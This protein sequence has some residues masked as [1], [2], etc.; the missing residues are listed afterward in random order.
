MKIKLEEGFLDCF[1][2]LEDP[3]SKR[4]RLYSMSEILLVTL[5][6]SICGAEG[7]QDV[8]DFGNIKIE[9][10]REYLPYKNGIPS[11]DTFRRFF[12]AINPD[13]FQELFREWVKI[14]A[15][16][17]N[18]NV[19]AIDGKSS[20]RSYDDDKKMLHTLSAYA[21]ES[22]LVLGQE[23]VSDKSNEIT[24]IP[25]LLDWL[26]IKGSIVTI[27]AM[28]CQHKIANKILEQQS[29]YIFC[30]KGNQGTLHEDIKLYFSDQELLKKNAKYYNDYDKAHG[31]IEHRKCSVVSDVD[32]LKKGHAEWKSIKSIILI[33][34]T[35]EIKGKVSTE[36]RYYISSLTQTPEKTLSSIRSHWAI[37][38][39]LHWVLDMSFGDDQCRIRKENA[40]QV[41]AVIRH[42]A[43]NL[44]QLAKAQMK[45]QSIKRLRKMAGWDNNMLSYILQQKF[46]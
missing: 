27:D 31:R 3:R 26:D 35:R 1:K 23:K 22:R 7:W 28:G 17:L 39:A 45:R 34:S 12:R 21:T 44:L 33:E 13:K 40:P 30:L 2:K 11:D 46:S 10:L 8:E 37:E 16:S 43:L 15:P 24:A 19:I 9:Y 14:I 38:N 6:A 29:N 25:Q 32:W 41:M 4:N 42:M 20:R 5:C 36:I 18:D